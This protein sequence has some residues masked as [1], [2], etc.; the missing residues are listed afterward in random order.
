MKQSPPDQNTSIAVR[1][2]HVV[3]SIP[4]GKVLTYGDVAELA[5]VKNPR[6]IGYLLHHNPDPSVIPCHRVVNFQGKCAKNFAF[7]M[8]KVQ[9]QLLQE[10]GVPFVGNNVDLSQAR[11]DGK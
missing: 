10:E 5:G 9:E 11:W 4:K 2:Y 1:V 8:Q 6:H 7:G 3:V